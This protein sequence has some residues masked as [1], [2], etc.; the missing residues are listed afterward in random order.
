MNPNIINATE[1]QLTQLGVE[2]YQQA[3]SIFR[4]CGQL[5]DFCV[6]DAGGL[7]FGGHNRIYLRKRGW[8]ASEDHCT[9]GFLTEFRK[10]PNTGVE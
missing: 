8:M 9:D 1:D 4:D 3:E 6:Q 2:V 7:V 10:L 5:R